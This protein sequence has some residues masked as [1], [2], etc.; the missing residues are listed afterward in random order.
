MDKKIKIYMKEITACTQCPEWPCG[1]HIKM[2]R[3]LKEIS[4]DCPLSDKELPY[5]RQWWESETGYADR[6]K[7]GTKVIMLKECKT[8]I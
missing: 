1:A 6:L 5:D 7:N 3:A 2:L 8:T 4:P